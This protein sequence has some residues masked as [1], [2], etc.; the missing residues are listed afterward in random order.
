MPRM[1]PIPSGQRPGE[2]EGEEDGHHHGRCGEDDAAGVGEAAD[3]SLA[4]VAAAVVVLLRGGEQEHRV[5]HRDCEDHREEEHGRPGV[6]EPL[7][8]VPEQP[9]PAAVLEDWATDAEGGAGGSRLVA[10]LSAAIS[11]ACSATSSS[12]K[13]SASDDADHERGLGGERVASRS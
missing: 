5:V 2:G 10:T 7:R 3:R 4:R 12:R 6:E 8:L 11:G 9:G 1:T 13:P